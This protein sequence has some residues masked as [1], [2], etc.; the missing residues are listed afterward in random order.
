MPVAP[1]VVPPLGVDK[2]R[3]LMKIR[4]WRKEFL[5]RVSGQKLAEKVR[6]HLARFEALRPHPVE[7]VA[8]KIAPAVKEAVREKPSEKIAEK[9]TPA[10]QEIPREKPTPRLTPSIEEMIQD[11][12]KKRQEQAAQEQKVTPAPKPAVK[13]KQSPYYAPTMSRPRQG[14]GMR[15]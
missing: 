12:Q 2:G 5:P 10:P 13:P 15:M 8:E 4:S 1:V 9:L 6:Q 14:R 11:L 7:A 3:L